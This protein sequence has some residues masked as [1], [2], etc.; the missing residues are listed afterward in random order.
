MIASAPA[1][2]TGVVIARRTLPLLLT[3]AALASCGGEEGHVDANGPHQP[4]SAQERLLAG[5]YR[6][7]AGALEGG[8]ADGICQGLAPRLAR[9]YRCSSSGAPRLPAQLRG[10]AVSDG[11][12]YAATDPT[13]PDEIQISAPTTRGDGSLI[14]FFLQD[15][16]EWRIKR[17]IVGGYG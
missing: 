10:I 4:A 15:G 6:D 8:D 14:V 1:R 3:G 5:R 17:A 16:D 9:S 12:I 11:E 13:I 7:F 2:S